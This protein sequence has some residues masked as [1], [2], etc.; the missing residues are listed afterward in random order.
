VNWDCTFETAISDLEVVSRDVNG[1]M[2]HFKY[3]LAGGET[4]EYIERD[5]D[6]TITLQETRDYISIATTRPETMLGDG[7]VA[8]HPSDTRYAPIVGKL[9]EIPVGPKEHRRLIPIIVDE[10][11]DPAFGSGAVKITGAHDA[12]DY[13]V[14]RRN[15]IPMYRLM[16]TRGQMRADGAPYAEQ[17]EK[18]RAIIA[19]GGQPDANEVDAINLV[20]DVYRGLDRFEA[21][22]RVVA[23]IEAEGLMIGVE[24]KKITQ[25]FGDRSNTVI[26]PMLTDQWFANA[27]ELAKP[28]IAAVREGRTA[29]VPKQWET[30]YFQWMENI[31][32]WCV[33]R[34]LWWGHQIPAWYGPEQSEP[35]QFDTL[36]RRIFVGLG[37]DAIRS[38]AEDHYGQGVVF[39]ADEGEFKARLARLR[40]AGGVGPIPLVRDPDVL[41]TWFSSA[42][43]PF[44][45]L[46]WPDKT[47]ELARYY[48]TDVLV[49]GFD[50]IFFWVARMMMMGLHFMKEEPFHTVYIHALVRDEKGAKMSKSKGNVIDPLSIIDDYGADAL[51]FTLAAM[52]AQGRDIKLSPAR[53]AGYRNFAT[54]LWNAT[55]FA[56]MNGCL[57]DAGFDPGS[58][59]ETVNRWIATEAA[60]ATAEVSAAI[61][62]Y[63][64]NDAASAAYRFV[65]NLVCDWYLELTK[66]ILQGNDEARKAETRAMTA[67]VIDESL[68]L[69]HPFMPFITEELWARTAEATDKP[70]ASLLVLTR[71][72]TTPV[73]DE[74]AAADEINWLI[75]LVTAIRSVRSEMN[76]PPATLMPLVLVGASDTVAAWARTHEAALK[77][78]ARLDAITTAEASPPASAQI[79]QAGYTA[80]LPLEGVID[81]AAE[82]ARLAKE[83]KTVTAD[84]AH[85]DKKLGN[86]DF[87]ARAPEEVIDEQKDKR[88]ALVE[89][90]IK[91]TEALQRLG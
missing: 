13:G 56:Q 43:W 18:A 77:R 51:R 40:L 4:Y 44:S 88:D 81:L 90:S 80:A 83:L 30:T 45:T 1:H 14:A 2:W 91:V 39:C 78:L 15:G 33:S 72:S 87:I 42:L 41:D 64:F 8:V 27:A 86:P 28:A 6:G 16:D 85:I 55:R 25:P 26:E 38:E 24:A 84:I 61:E 22:A 10:Y 48:Q 32:P 29:I 62:A 23:D 66:P 53:I 37:E 76:V 3:P 79:V 35:Y 7:A 12:N 70:R 54:K 59:R 20:P 89:R 75:D 21:R 31:Q 11:P 47:P 58:A 73:P 49:T 82:K 19:R 9:C 67:Y 68:K 74:T 57:P 17:V 34:Q 5:A 52:A 65:W 63:R 50:I 60:R 69:L 36:A 71:W 46:G